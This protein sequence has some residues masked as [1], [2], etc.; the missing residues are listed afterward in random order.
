MLAAAVAAVLMADAARAYGESDRLR[1]AVEKLRAGRGALAVVR[2]AGTAQVELLARKALSGLSTGE[3]ELLKKLKKRAAAAREKAKGIATGATMEV[4][5][6]K[7][8]GETDEITADETVETGEI[9]ASGTSEAEIAEDEPFALDTGETA[10]TREVAIKIPGAGKISVRPAAGGTAETELDGNASTREVSVERAEELFSMHC[11]QCHP[12]GKASKM[13]GPI[14]GKAFFRSN[15]DK[16]IIRVLRTGRRTVR[17]DMPPYDSDRL[18]DE[19][20]AALVRH[21][22][23]LGGEGKTGE[24]NLKNKTGGSAK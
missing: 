18:S 1:S 20:A 7:S 10:S 14:A 16:K 12:G 17:A 21:M 11:D 5:L 22:K 6:A 15:D 2:G 9:T 19:E 4:V 13:S 3:T 8:G 23:T 24:I